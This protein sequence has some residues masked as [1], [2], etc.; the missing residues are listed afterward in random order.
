MIS[1]SALSLPLPPSLT[2]SLPPSLPLPLSL[3]LFS[4]PLA[5]PPSFLFPY[6]VPLSIPPPLSP[7][8]LEVTG[9]ESPIVVGLSGTLLCSTILNVTSIKWY[10]TATNSVLE[11]SSSS[12]V[13]YRMTPNSAA[14][15]G[16]RYTCK[17]ETASGEIYSKTVDILVKGMP[18]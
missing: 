17:A 18:Q 6:V 8:A 4:L 12:S 5:F 1:P 9:Y 10:L 14:L 15:N 3:I 2:F 16:T 11:S 7:S 13:E